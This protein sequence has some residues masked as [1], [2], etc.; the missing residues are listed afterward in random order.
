MSGDVISLDS[1]RGPSV[2]TF[3]CECGSAWFNARVCLEGRQVTGYGV[4]IVC[5]ECGREVTP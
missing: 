3:L 1:R 2:P 4:P 5:V